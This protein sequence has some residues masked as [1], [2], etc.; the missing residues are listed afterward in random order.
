M[1]TSHG[2]TSTI[3]WRPPRRARWSTHDGERMCE[4]FTRAKL[5]VSEFARQT[6]VRE[7]KVR[8]WLKRARRRTSTPSFQPVPMVSAPPVPLTEPDGSLEVRFADG[9]ITI[10][11]RPGFDEATFGR[12]AKALRLSK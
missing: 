9:A 5:S 8:Y 10:A 3:G 12:V 7:L 6:G 2:N 11:V 1:S 4:A